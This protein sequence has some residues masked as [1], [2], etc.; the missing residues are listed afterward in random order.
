MVL[1]LY[2]AIHVLTETRPRAVYPANTLS[3]ARALFFAVVIGFILPSIALF[4]P[5]SLSLD[6]KQIIAAIWQGFPLYIG[7]AFKLLY[8]L[9]VSLFR[10]ASKD[11]QSVDDQTQRALR[12]L[13]GTYIFFGLVS[14]VI[15]IVIFLPSL[16]AEDSRISFAEIFVPY[17]LHPYVPFESLSPKTLPLYRL[18]ARLFFQYDWLAITSSALIFFTGTSIACRAT[19]SSRVSFTGWIACMLLLGT[20]GGPGASLAWAAWMYE[21]STWNV[22]RSKTA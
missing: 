22:T 6:E 20:I 19:S 8:W 15:H 9:D 17:V 1:P 7:L 16:A 11:S 21:R 3:R 5:S 10:S 14:A 2:F 18:A 13:K 4:V 12:W